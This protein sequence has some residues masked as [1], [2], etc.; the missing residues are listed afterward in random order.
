MSKR[1]R[2]PSFFL[3]NYGMGDQ[4]MKIHTPRREV[5]RF[6]ATASNPKNFKR[7]GPLNAELIH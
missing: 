7:T 5:D 1:G 6:H 3:Q 2:I 4:V